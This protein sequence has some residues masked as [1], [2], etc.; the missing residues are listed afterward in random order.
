MRGRGVQLF[1]IVKG[2]PNRA[3]RFYMVPI[4]HA[5]ELGRAIIAA[6]RSRF[7]GQMPE[8]YTDFEKQY[9]ARAWRNIEGRVSV[10]SSA[11]PQ[12]MV[13]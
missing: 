6:V 12:T 5:E 2:S 8:W 9:E 11:Y 3:T 13:E 10:L 1:A 4:E 7:P